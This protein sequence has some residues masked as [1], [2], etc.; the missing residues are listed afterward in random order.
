MRSHPRAKPTPFTSA[1]APERTK[2]FSSSL[3]IVDAVRFIRYTCLCRQPLPVYRE[4][5]ADCPSAQS[6]PARLAES[7]PEVS[8]DMPARKVGLLRPKIQKIT[9]QRL[10]NVSLTLGNVARIFANRTW[11]T[12]TGLSDEFPLISEH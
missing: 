8:D 10:R 1:P 5:A 6:R 11:P 12:E 4:A 7:L 3:R 2:T 9:P